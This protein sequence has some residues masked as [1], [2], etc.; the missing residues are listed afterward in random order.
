MA[1]IGLRLLPDTN[2]DA[3]FGVQFYDPM[4]AAAFNKEVNNQP[5]FVGYQH[6]CGRNF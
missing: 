6:S 2:S 5:Q 4:I 1:G 3:Y